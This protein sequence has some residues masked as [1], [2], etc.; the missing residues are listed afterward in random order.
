[1]KVLIIGGHGYIGSVLTNT[2]R[3]AG[4]DVSTYGDRQNDYNLLTKDQLEEFHYVVLLAGHSSV[5][6]CNGELKG[7]WNNNVRNF[8]TLVEKLDS[9]QKLIY[10]SSSSVYGSSQGRIC[11]ESDQCLS[12]MNNY[13]LTKIVLDQVASNY[14]H[15]GR[16]LIGLRFGTVVGASSVLRNDILVNSMTYSAIIRGEI[17]VTNPNIRRPFLSIND[18][19]LGILKIIQGK[20]VSGIYNMANDNLRIIDYAHAVQSKTGV[21]IVDKG[22]TPGVYDFQIDPSLFIDTF[23][24]KYTDHLEN[25]VDQL[26]NTYNT[27]SC[28]VVSRTSYLEYDG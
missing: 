5:P 9:E 18:L 1:M 19:C 23:Q 11:V 7:P 21:N 25:L 20:F 24:F 22:T 8:S 2:L 15:A 28:K 13:D 27:N 12:Y 26:I 10:A 17:H 16:Q 4:V 14:I 3:S 6:S